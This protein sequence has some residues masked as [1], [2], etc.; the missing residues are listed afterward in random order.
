MLSDLRS[1][2]RYVRSQPG[3]SALAI[4]SLAVAI[5]VNAAMFSV[6]SAFLLRDAVDRDPARYVGVFTMT[7]DAAR[8]YRPF[9]W[10]EFN[11]LRADRTVFA[12]VSAVFYSQVALGREVEA[13]RAFAFLV[14][15]NFFA[16]AGVR[17]AAGRFFTADE[18]APSSGAAV[19]VVSQR[20]WR[21]HGGD[22]GL[23]GRT[24]RINGRDCTVVG[25][26]PEGFSGASPLL[27]PEMWL[28]LGFFAHVTPAFA[29]HRTAPDLGAPHNYQL[30]LFAR[31][32]PSLSRA[33][34]LPLLPVLAR[35]LAT[36]EPEP[37]STARELVLARPFGI[38]PEPARENA[39]GPVTALTLGLSTL[40]LV[41][42]C[43]NLGNLLLA[44]GTTRGTEIATRLA[45][46]ASRARVVRQLLAEGLL[47]GGAGALLGVWCS[48]WVG[49]LLAQV[50]ADRVAEFGFTV[51]A[52]FQPDATVLAV[53]ALVSLLACLGFSLGPALRVSRVDLANDLRSGAGG[54]IAGAGRAWWSGRNLLQI[55]QSALSLVLLFAAGLF[56]RSAV[57]AA[58]PPTGLELS[59]RA[60]AEVDFALAPAPHETRRGRLLAA[61]DAA[62][63]APGLAGA[64]ITSLVPYANDVQIF[65]ASRPDATGAT[66][67]P[68]IGAFAAVS[69]G[70]IDTISSLLRGRD[71]TR[72]EAA[73]PEAAAVC[74]VD[75][76]FARRLFPQGDALGET[77][78]LRGGPGRQIHGRFTIVGIAAA[79]SQDV[80]DRAQPLP[81]VFVPLARVDHPLW[82]VVA[83]GTAAD[84]A[85]ARAT[86]LSL[87]TADRDLPLL[88]VRP[89]A[90]FVGNN[91]GRWQAGLGAVLFG[92]FALVSAALAAVGVYGVTSYAMAR[93]TREI[94][95]RLALGA[96][97]ADIALLVLRSGASQLAAA[98][99]LGGVIAMGV[100]PLLAGFV[101]NVRSFDAGALAL[102][103]AVL[104][105]AA[106]IA[107]ALPARRAARVDP[108]VAL[109][110]E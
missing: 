63:R 58:G 99:A 45:L 102:A 88:A 62:R 77:V 7:R 28:P 29:G 22:G 38:A 92:F 2:W 81:R 87:R 57:A 79:H 26:A 55:G 11:A 89:L 32:Q 100:G 18:A 47:V 24:L 17:P 80:A 41:V 21:A 31:L 19:V 84:S 44:R 72:A 68:L 106:M 65:R 105:L 67:A 23:I 94:G 16:L 35:R 70:Y 14:S 69:D 6:V 82:F 74:I 61:L 103:L 50:L 101:P 71:F 97:R 30:Q 20:L 78:E 43:L 108:L 73:S 90:D 66:I 8:T 93:R 52:G 42:A 51:V 3:F 46:G 27:A 96:G 1:A 49:T 83:K 33:S 56:L 10:A 85:V 91:F 15:E 25:V 76:Q 48:W 36:I 107:L 109:R 39:F 53:T 13:R 4:V 5:G 59:G 34:A 95:V 75:E 98:V 86:S 60:V 12:D 9:S 54:V 37:A 110:S 104:L 40:V 64:G